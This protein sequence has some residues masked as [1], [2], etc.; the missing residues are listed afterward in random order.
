MRIDRINSGEVILSWKGSYQ[1]HT[2]WLIILTLLIALSISNTCFTQPVKMNANLGC[3]YWLNPDFSW[4]SMNASHLVQHQSWVFLWATMVELPPVFN[5]SQHNKA[6]L[7][8]A[9]WLNLN[10]L[11]SYNREAVSSCTMQQCWCVASSL[12][13]REVWNKE[14]EGSNRRT[15]RRRAQRMQETSMRKTSSS[16]SSF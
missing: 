4:T 7:P 13:L 8:S 3:A 10:M 1:L 12:S 9:K 16:S 5:T 11:M 2:Q 15:R 6:N 14:R